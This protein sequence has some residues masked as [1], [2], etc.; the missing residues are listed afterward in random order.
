MGVRLVPT[1]QRGN[2]YHSLPNEPT[3]DKCLTPTVHWG[4]VDKDSAYN[5]V[6]MQTTQAGMCSHAGAWEQGI[7]FLDFR[8]KRIILITGYSLLVIRGWL[9]KNYFSKKQKGGNYDYN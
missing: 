4:L 8:G 1:L 2:A 5:P 6:W 9:L 3:P 7:L